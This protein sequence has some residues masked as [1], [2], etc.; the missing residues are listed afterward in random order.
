MAMIKVIFDSQNSV[1]PVKQECVQKIKHQESRFLSIFRFT[2]IKIKTPEE[3]IKALEESMWLHSEQTLVLSIYQ[4]MLQ[5]V[6]TDCL[7]WGLA[8]FHDCCLQQP[9]PQIAYLI[10]Q[11]KNSWWAWSKE[12]TNK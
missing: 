7:C 11:T 1:I 10:S 8:E 9:L 3:S 5:G 6:D 12:P 4:Q 2:T